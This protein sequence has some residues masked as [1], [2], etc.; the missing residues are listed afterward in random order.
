[1]NVDERDGFRFINDTDYVD[2]VGGYHSPGDCIN[3][4]GH[5]CGDC[6]KLSCEPCPY[7]NLE[8]PEGEE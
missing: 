6:T 8:G 5:F 2:P 4:R 1:M 7:R 3:P